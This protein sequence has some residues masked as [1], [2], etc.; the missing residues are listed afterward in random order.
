MTKTTTGT[1]T[2][3]SS[4]K[5][6]KDVMQTI[7]TKELNPSASAPTISLTVSG[8]NGEVG[9]SYNVPAATLKLTSV[10]SYT[11]GPKT[12]ITVPASKASVSCTTEGTST[13]NGAA[14]AAN[15]T[16]E[17]AAGAFKKYAD[18]STTYSYSAE[19]TYTDGTVPVTNLG[20]AYPDA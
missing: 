3:A 16:V 4:G 13:T 6:L 15:G 8:G 2:I 11:Y 18:G 1:T 19:A 14:L 20:T 7:F 17:L 12:G 5:S 10:G 9:S